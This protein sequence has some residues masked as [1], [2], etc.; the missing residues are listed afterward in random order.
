MTR[1][2]QHRPLTIALRDQLYREV[3]TLLDDRYGESTLT[4]EDVAHEVASSRR[5][6]QRLF[7]EDGDTFRAYLTRLRMARAAELLTQTA[8]P[9]RE[10]AQSVGYRQSA[11]FAKAFRRFSGVTP[12]QHR[13]GRGGAAGADDRRS[14]AA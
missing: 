8:A 14:V 12:M 1:P 4:L 3:R 6:V 7:E 2:V 9:V 13:T 5:Q 11:Q 10:I